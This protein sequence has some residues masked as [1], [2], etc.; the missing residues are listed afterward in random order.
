[1]P[2]MPPAALEIGEAFIHDRHSSLAFVGRTGGWPGIFANFIGDGRGMEFAHIDF[3]VDDDLASWRAEIPG[4]DLLRGHAQRSR[5]GRRSILD[6][7]VSCRS[8]VDSSSRGGRMPRPF[9][10]AF[11]LCMGLASPVVPQ[12][13]DHGTMAEQDATVQG[14]AAARMSQMDGHHQADPHMRMTARRPPTE[15]DRRRAGQLLASLRQSL[16]RYKDYRVAIGDGYTPFLPNLPLPE[17]HFTNYRYAFR[18]A[19]RFDPSQPSSLL[20]R[21]R[22]DGYELI[23]AMYTARKTAG[24]KELDERVPLSVATWHA[25]VNICL[26]ERGASRP[27]WSRFGLKGSI[28]TE[29]NCR[30]TNGRWFPQLFGWMV[31]V[32]PYETSTEKIWGQ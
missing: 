13:H 17:Y 5:L 3:Q 7:Q 18:D 8:G 6:W 31:H 21:K 20:Y 22:G 2:K 25:H 1:M 14:Q 28:V 27:D 11:L 23:G 10:I 12:E 26:P 30:E 32:Y 4:P 9:P 29:E 19:F 15:D 24:E 16:E